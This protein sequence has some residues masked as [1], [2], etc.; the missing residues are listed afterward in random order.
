MKL[1]KNVKIQNILSIDFDWI[2]SLKDMEELIVYIYKNINKD[3]KIIFSYYH[4][5]IYPLF[6]HG[7]DEYNLI[8]I[9][10]HHDY[11]HDV[12]KNNTLNEGNWLFHLSN[13]F[14][15]KINYTW[16]SKNDSIP[17]KDIN[18]RK[19]LK[20]FKFCNFVSDIPNIDFDTFF[21]CRSPEYSNQFSNTSYEIIRKIYEVK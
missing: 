9:D 20:D 11:S 12:N 18:L 3:K 2:E 5:N 21:F 19:N 16:I 1:N 15:N 17:N 14:C 8:N 6:K 7:V 4:D 13:I 10:K